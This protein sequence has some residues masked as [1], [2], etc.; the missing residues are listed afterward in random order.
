MTMNV[1]SV[2]MRIILVTT[3]TSDKTMAT[4]GRLSCNPSMRAIHRHYP[5]LNGGD[6]HRRR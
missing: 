6:L 5:I 4:S 2:G 3:K 1:T